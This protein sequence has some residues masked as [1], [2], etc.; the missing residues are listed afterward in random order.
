[1]FLLLFTSTVN[2]QSSR[3]VMTW[4]P[5]Y[6][7]EKCRA[8]LQQAVDGIGPKDG[9][10]DLALQFWLPT[11]EGG[12]EKTSKYGAI[13]DSVIT[14]LRDWAHQQGIRALLC[15]YNNNGSWDWALAE[16]AFANHQQQFVDALVAETERLGL[17]G[18]DIDLE[19]NGD[20]ETSKAAFVAFLRDLST[21]LHA[22]HKQLTVDSFA[23]Q[24][25]APNQTWWA[26][27]FP[28]VDGLNTM[29]YEEIGAQ[30]DT[31]RA[32]AAQRAAA[33]PEAT[34]LLIGM[35]ANK[36]DWRGNTVAEHMEWITRDPR[37]GVAIWDATFAAP[38]WQ[39]PAAWKALAQIRARPK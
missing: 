38:Y 7:I 34:K 19:G 27:L 1:M 15:V 24:W 12:V 10:T 16:A 25:N 37:V 35:P 6:S 4:V 30:A 14:E 9:L 20:F 13:K 17:D 29:G 11:V 28:L 36:A 39:T 26:E 18:V 33:G 23:Y 22:A 2:A 5:P 21:R 3:M 31:W 8:R 32:Y